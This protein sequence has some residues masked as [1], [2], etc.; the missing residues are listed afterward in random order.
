MLK[1]KKILLGITGSVAAYKAIDLIKLFRNKGAFVEVI[2]T[3]ASARFISPMSISVASGSRVHTDM[4]EEHLAHINLPFASDLF[5]IAPATANTISKCANGIADDLLSSALLAYDRKA[6]FA[7]AMNW[8]MYENPGFQ[9]NLD[10]LASL[11]HCFVGPEKGSLACGEQGIGRMSPVEHI[12]D[13]AAA[14]MSRQDL[15]GHKV[16]VTAGPT[17]EYIDPVRYITNR[18]SGK[19]GFAVARAARRRGASVTLIKGPCSIEPPYGVKVVDVDSAADMHKEVMQRLSSSTILIMSAAVA[20]FTPYAMQDKKIEKTET[21][22]LNLVRTVDIIADA[23]ASDKRPFIIG[24]SAE[25]GSSTDRAVK[26]LKVK[27]MDMIVFNDVSRSDIGFDCDMNE[28]VIIDKKGS[29]SLP[30]L[31][32]DDTAEAI[33]DR[34]VELKKLSDKE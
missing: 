10:Y 9:R 28:V 27:N 5:I 33:L 6:L 29:T 15:S 7:P 21:I 13:A 1:D 16:L 22:T 3:D 20:D 26:K 4:F 34:A 31:S 19:M 17:R 11:G 32:K 18:S 14:C 24:F 25:T 8:R 12:A 2:M 30:L 23:A